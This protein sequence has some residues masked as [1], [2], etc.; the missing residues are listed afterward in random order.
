MKKESEEESEESERSE[1]N[2]INIDRESYYCLMYVN[3]MKIFN[4]NIM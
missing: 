3:T 4:G 2:I 1:E